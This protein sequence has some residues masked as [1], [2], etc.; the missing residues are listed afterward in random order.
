VSQSDGPG[1][2]LLDLI[3]AGFLHLRRHEGGVEAAHFDVRLGG[4]SLALRLA[5]P[6]LPALLRVSVP[7]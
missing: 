7:T 6:A 5:G 2:R 3:D 4:P 1:P